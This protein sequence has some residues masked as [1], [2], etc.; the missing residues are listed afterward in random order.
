MSN[1]FMAKCHCIAIKNT[2]KRHYRK[3]SVRT[4][5]KM[6][7]PKASLYGRDNFLWVITF[8]SYALFLISCGPSLHLINNYPYEQLTTS[9]SRRVSVILTGRDVIFCRVEC[10]SLGED[11]RV[12]FGLMAVRR[13]WW[14]VRLES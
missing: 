7:G 2:A 14:I 6:T 5:L 9:L 8:I 3:L 11:G 12:V 4:L 13:H 10:R 1:Y